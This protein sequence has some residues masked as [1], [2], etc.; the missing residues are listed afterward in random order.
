MNQQSIA[1]VTVDG[2]P[3]GRPQHTRRESRFR[4]FCGSKSGR[5]R[6]SRSSTR[7]RQPADC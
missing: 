4:R 1:A 6:R 2:S 5:A 7:P 3:A